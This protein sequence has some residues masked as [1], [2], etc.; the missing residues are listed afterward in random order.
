MRA[1]VFLCLLLAG[2]VSGGV[3]P[4][5]ASGEWRTGRNVDGVIVESRE[6][7]SRYDEHRGSVTLCA[8]LQTV[9]LFVADVDGLPAWVPYTEAAEKIEEGANGVIYHVVT[10]APWPYRSRDM[11]YALDVDLQGNTAT[12]TMTGLPGRLAPRPGL[13]R[14]TAARGLWTFVPA[15]DALQV[16]LQLWVD[17]GGGPGMLVNRRAGTTL[18]R[19]L[20]NLQD[21]FPCGRS[22]S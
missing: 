18:G 20:A 8:D 6:V 4:A 1:G 7:D 11:I 19:M 5:E 14:M 9:L 10:G 3:L 12:V 15:G 16:D 17:P 13:V 22:P 21:H 2:F